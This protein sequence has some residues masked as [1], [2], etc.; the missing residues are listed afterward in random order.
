MIG[1]AALG[2][3]GARWLVVA[4]IGAIALMG[5]AAT[6]VPTMQAQDVPALKAVVDDRDPVSLLPTSVDSILTVDLVR[7]RSSS[8]AGP[9]LKPRGHGEVA[10]SEVA[11]AEQTAA[12]EEL[13]ASRTRRGFDEVADVDLWVFA[14]TGS[15]G[16]ERGLLELARG[17]FDRGRVRSA[18]LRQ[19]PGAHATQFGN[20]SGL[21]TPTVAVV[22]LSETVIGFGPPWALRA[23]ADVMDARQPS[24][25]GMQ[26]LTVARGALAEVGPGV[27]PGMK[28]AI[29]LFLRASTQVRAE[30]SEAVS[31]DM[32]IEHL[33]ARIEVGDEAR[34]Y[35]NAAVT[36]KTEA[37]ELAVKLREA[38]A[39]LR[40][41]PSI[42]ALGLGPVVRR[43]QIDSRGPRVVMGLAI[44]GRQRAQVAEKLAA[45]ATVLARRRE[46]ARAQAAAQVPGHV[47][48]P[49]EESKTASQSNPAAGTP[50]SSKNR[51]EN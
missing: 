4:H 44:T 7:L 6:P 15:T 38:L 36:S 26:W 31:I 18:F 41:R 17:R 23:A 32:P 42:E 8:F 16:G 45:F 49:T 11:A 22:F 9:F 34:A 24:L 29:E 40:G 46:E 51:P 13:T 21:T 35:F 10:A 19:W 39:G 20:S 25:R 12:A 3:R 50:A 1:V 47:R 5:C 27:R 48:L 33:S 37:D 43:A 30:L 28:T 2:N 14:R